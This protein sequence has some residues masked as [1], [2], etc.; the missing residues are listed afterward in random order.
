MKAAEHAAMW[1]LSEEEK[2]E[3]EE[4]RK[5]L[6]EVRIF[7]IFCVSLLINLVDRRRSERWRAR[8][9]R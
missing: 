1:E 9:R 8:R 5:K 3:Q 2:H 6:L 7:M 4:K